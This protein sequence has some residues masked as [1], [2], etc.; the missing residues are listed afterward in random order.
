MARFHL[1]PTTGRE[2][3]QSA[4]ELALTLPMLLL[5]VLGTLDLGRALFAYVAVTNAAREGARFATDHPTNAA[6]ITQRV[7]QEIGCTGC[8]AIVYA[9]SKYADNS[10]VACGS[11]E[12]GDRVGVQVSYDFELISSSLLPFGNSITLSNYAIMAITNGLSSP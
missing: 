4:V 5:I 3:G 11:A 8:V 10:A 6:G 9:C 7:D 12:N 2:H 1:L